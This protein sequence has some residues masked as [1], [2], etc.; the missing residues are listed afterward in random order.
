M[1]RR[2]RWTLILAVALPVVLV[3]NLFGF[4]PLSVRLFGGGY[5]SISAGSMKP[6]LMP[7]DMILSLP[8]RDPARGDVVVFRHPQN[9]ADYVARIVGLAGEQVQMTGGVLHIGGV[10]AGMAPVEDFV[11]SQVP[12]GTPPRPPRC[13]RPMP[14]PGG[15]CLKEQWVETL[16]DG[17]S[18][19]ILNVVG[20]IGVVGSGRSDE[21]PVFSIPDDHVF[22]MGD[23]RDNA[24]DSRAYGPVAMADVKHRVWRV[25]TSWAPGS[26]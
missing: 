1:S 22:V 14:K 8:V 23:H 24:I 18:H 9:R 25:L 11:E 5:H 12:R 16:P 26:S 17:Q 13:R 7:G 3:W 4:S 15:D 19:R 20:T 21:T 10:A 2:L 6:A